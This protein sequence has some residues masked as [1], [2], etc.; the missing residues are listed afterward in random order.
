MSY[1]ILLIR[2]KGLFKK[3]ETEIDVEKLKPQF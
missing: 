1:M 3:L 2:L